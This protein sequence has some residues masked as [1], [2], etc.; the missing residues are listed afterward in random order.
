M[1]CPPFASMCV[2]CLRKRVPEAMRRAIGTWECISQ[3]GVS[4]RLSVFKNGWI[5][6]C[7]IN[8]QDR[9]II[10]GQ[11]VRWEMKGPTTAQVTCM[12]YCWI[13]FLNLQVDRV[14]ADG[15]QDPLMSAHTAH[16]ARPTLKVNGDTYVGMR[17]AGGLGKPTHFSLKNTGKLSR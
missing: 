4:I 2:C 5:E 3:E 16:T 10:S 15:E 8:H 7:E 14:V 13:F 1:P 17:T 12:R 11:A 9:R 6:M